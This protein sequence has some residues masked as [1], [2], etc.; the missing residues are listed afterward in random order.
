PRAATAADLLTSLLKRA[1]RGFDLSKPVAGSTA[2]TH[3][4]S[5]SST[6]VNGI[7][8]AIGQKMEL[9]FETKRCIHARFCVTGAPNVFLAN[10]KGPWINPD[11]IDVDRLVEISHA[12]PSGAIKYKRKDGKADETPPPVN[13]I[14]IREAGPYAV[15]A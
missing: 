8:T 2:T 4:D 9:S 3:N 15:H 7:E 6:V 10:V 11:A 5:P 13:L 12:C 14:A 1:T